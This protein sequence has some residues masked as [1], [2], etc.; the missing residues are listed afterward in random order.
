MMKVDVKTKNVFLKWKWDSWL[1]HISTLGMNNGN[2]YEGEA[3]SS[4]HTFLDDD[5]SIGSMYFLPLGFAKDFESLIAELQDSWK[6]WKTFPQHL[7]NF[8]FRGN[9]LGMLLVEDFLQTNQYLLHFPNSSDSEGK[10]LK[11]TKVI[12]QGL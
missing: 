11:K 8:F 3:S 12:I 7:W 9:Y 6:G 5:R 1:N 2:K 10:A 4:K